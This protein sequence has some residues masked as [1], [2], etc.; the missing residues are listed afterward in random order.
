MQLRRRREPLRAPRGRPQRGPAQR[1]VQDELEAGRPG[2]RARLRQGGEGRRTR[3]RVGGSRVKVRRKGETRV[4]Y[5]K[6]NKL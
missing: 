5:S 3:V 4:C 6:C 2:Q 1:A